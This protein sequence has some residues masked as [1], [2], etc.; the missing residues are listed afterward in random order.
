MNR[1]KKKAEDTMEMIKE[2]TLQTEDMYKTP[3]G[4]K[5]GM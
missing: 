1:R 4:K 5:K 3:L 2:L